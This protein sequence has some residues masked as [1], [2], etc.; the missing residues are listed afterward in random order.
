M[1]S[2]GAAR[3]SE[4]RNLLHPP[5]MARI[6]I[7][8]GVIACLPLFGCQAYERAPLSL[9]DHMRSVGARLRAP[10]PGADKTQPASFD[11]ANGAALAE[12]ETF[13]L[14]YNHDLRL[15]RERA[16]IARAT[17]ENAGLWQDPVFGFDG[18][19]V[20]SP[21]DDF[22]YGAVLS[23]TLPIS[24]RLSRECDR[25]EAAYE[26]ELRRIAD[27]EWNVRADIR[28]AY[29]RWSS[30][31]RQRELLD[32]LLEDVAHVAAIADQLEAAGAL[33]KAQS[34]LIRIEEV[35]R[36]AE[37][38]AVELEADLARLSILGLMGLAPDAAIALQ[39]PSLEQVV[40]PTERA[41]T[42]IVGTS[43]RLAL[44]RAEYELT[45][46]SLR[47]A[48]RRQYPDLG[49]GLGPGSADEDTRVIL[50]ASLPLPLWNRN[51]QGIAQARAARELARVAAEVGLEQV[52]RDA[53]RA[54]LTLGSIQAQRLEIEGALQPLLED[55]AQTIAELADLGDVDAFV[56][57][58]SLRRRYDAAARLLELEANEAG[59]AVE[60]I[61]LVGPPTDA[62]HGDD[63]TDTTEIRKP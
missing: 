17:R 59:A 21:G 27:A 40:T 14:F 25:A 11:L 35:G 36:R 60:L 29:F 56:A 51:A 5:S 30:L 9:L 55:Q 7:T 48:I 47:L 1:D 37:L 32:G 31:D 43:T 18:A 54:A 20:L 41:V 13:A 61:R 24:G 52:V 6:P 26:V 23:L 10:L 53:E 57:L 50:G 63:V 45:E 3:S 19:Q 33:G 38:L 28:R 49:L 62:P 15:A 39:Q 58:E 2:P 44:L 8:I 16:G 46:Q 42:D 22:E 4:Q 12:C 34:R